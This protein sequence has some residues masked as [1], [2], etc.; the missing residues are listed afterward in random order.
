MSFE[1]GQSGCIMDGRLTST[2]LLPHTGEPRSLGH[3]TRRII[4]RGRRQEANIDASPKS[5]R[6]YLVLG[7]AD[8]ELQRGVLHQRTPKPPKIVNNSLTC[9]SRNLLADPLLLFS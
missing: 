9:W 3:T 8:T 7:P 1:E 2:L 6:W 4:R 5:I